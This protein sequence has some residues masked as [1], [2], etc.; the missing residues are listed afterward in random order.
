MFENQGFKYPF[1]TPMQGSITET[2]SK[3]E[4]FSRSTGPPL[5]LL[6]TT[7]PR[8]RGSISNHTY[9]TT[10]TTKAEVF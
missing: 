1:F 7:N 8:E 4:H 9:T 3:V 6:H 10:I 2:Q 5:D